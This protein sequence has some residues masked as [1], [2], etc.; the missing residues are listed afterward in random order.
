MNMLHLLSSIGGVLIVCALIGIVASGYVKSP[1]NVAFIISGFRKEPRVLIGRAGIKLPFL[2]RKDVLLI[3]QISV[4][5]KTNGYIPTQDFIGVDVDAVAKIRVKTD[6]EGIQVAMKNFLNMS[7]ND[8]V[9]ALT[10]SLQGNMREIIG[11]IT[12]KDIC[13]DRKKFGDEVQEKAQ[14]DM[15][16]LGI[17]IISCNIQRVDDE[18]NLINALGQDNMA[19]IQK[20]ASIAKANADKE[21]AIAE[22]NAQEQANK[23]KVDAAKII[24][25][26][27]NELALKEAEL[28]AVEET[29]RA[30]AEAA[31]E[32]EKQTQQKTVVVRTQEAEIAKREKEIELQTREAEVAEKKL[33][34]EVRKKAEAEKF[35]AQQKADAD[36]YVRQKEAEA[37]LVEKQKAA[38]AIKVQGEAEAE[39]IRAKG[40]AEAEAIEKKA[41]AMKQYGQAAMMEMIVNVL[42]DIAKNVAEPL[43][44]IEKVSII[45]G[46]GS[47]ISQV[48][49]NVPV[50]MQQVFETVKETTGLD[51]KD[52][53]MANSK[54][55]KTDR[56]ITVQTDL[57]LKEAIKDKETNKNNDVVGTETKEENTQSKK[58]MS[59]KETVEL[60][61]KATDVIE[62]ALEKKKK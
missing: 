2:E 28:K 52:I 27:N 61:Q 6:R 12:L 51:L 23:A 22:A 57:P 49:N 45:G 37:Q 60:I 25:E 36:L 7:E 43:A 16:A 13:N 9:S 24:A 32:Q 44:S 53:V 48:S 15:N 31:Y 14:K 19:Q 62:K 18:N 33:D 3:K 39:A 54:A 1:P 47:G 59:E 30:I 46:D 5:I 29:K 50:V 58:D 38:E 20:D 10:D 17:E 41:E 40:L 21:V 56:N 34:A 55:A 35:A 8:I 42:P 11:T 26:R 4:D